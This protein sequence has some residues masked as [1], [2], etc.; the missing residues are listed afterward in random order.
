M[1]I[2]LKE[3]QA[4][5]HADEKVKAIEEE[6]ASLTSPE[7][8]N[9]RG[10]LLHNLT[11]AYA[12]RAKAKAALRACI[13]KATHPPFPSKFQGSLDLTIATTPIQKFTGDLDLDLVF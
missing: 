9:L 7:D 8:Q 6:L 5:K 12:V 10:T 4:Y 1:P 3:Q 11:Q 2:C 13:Y